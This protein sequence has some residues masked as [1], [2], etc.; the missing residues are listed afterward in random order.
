MSVSSQS[1]ELIELM[2]IQSFLQKSNLSDLD[3]VINVL[4]SLLLLL[5]LI[6]QIHKTFY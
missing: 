5:L 3:I 2:Y 4:L 1:F 6:L